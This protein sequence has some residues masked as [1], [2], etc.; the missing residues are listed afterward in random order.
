MQL[1]LNGKPFIIQALGLK[2]SERYRW[3]EGDGLS[4]LGTVLKELPFQESFPRPPRTLHKRIFKST[5]HI[6][7][8][9]S[10]PNEEVE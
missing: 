1:F 9:R 5:S 3:G 7:K 10:L 4:C 8:Y 2:C 6:L